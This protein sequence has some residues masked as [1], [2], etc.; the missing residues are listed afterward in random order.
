VA[1]NSATQSGFSVTV[2]TTVPAGSDLQTANVSGGTVGKPEAG[3]TVTFT[4]SEPIEPNSVLAAW[5]GTSTSVTVRF[6]D[7]GLA[8]DT[9]QVWNSANTSQLPL[10]QVNLGRIDYVAA[11]VDFAGSTMAQSASSITI[12]LGTASGGL[13]STALTASA[14][15]WSPSASAT[16]RAGNACST[17][18]VTE[19]GSSDKD[20]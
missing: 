7:G 4:F 19:S 12:T 6:V 10:G 18:V 13:V 9:L 8:N 16:D 14:M 5:T 1:G 2:D 3:D 15:V 20:F 17:S 11:N